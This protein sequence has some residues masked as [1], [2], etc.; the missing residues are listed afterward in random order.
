MLVFQQGV[1]G[2]T[3]AAQHPCSAESS[4]TSCCMTT[5]RHRHLRGAAKTLRA[6]AAV[7]A[8][9]IEKPPVLFFTAMSGDGK[10]NEDHVLSDFLMLLLPKLFLTATGMPMW[11]HARVISVVVGESVNTW[12]RRPA[13]L[14]RRAKALAHARR[15]ISLG[16]ARD[17]AQALARALC[18]ARHAAN[19]E[20]LP[21]R[22]CRCGKR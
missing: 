7:L 14:C 21:G 20:I 10:R 12:D 5:V 9:R 19:A 3:R 4:S 11:K 13:W 16:R 22:S 15:P 2:R 1:N 8:S 17:A 6:A 18:M